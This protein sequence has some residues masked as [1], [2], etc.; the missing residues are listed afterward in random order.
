[1]TSFANQIA[2]TGS[3]TT[4]TALAFTVT[5]GI[6]NFSHLKPTYLYNLLVTN[7]QGL[8]MFNKS[9]LYLSRDDTQICEGKVGRIKY[10]QHLPIRLSYMCRNLCDISRA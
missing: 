7:K 8:I 6:G 2:P 10:V 9:L 4:T 5:D 1:M 3:A